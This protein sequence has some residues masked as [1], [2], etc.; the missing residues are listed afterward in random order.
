M[1]A[2][3]TVSVTTFSFWCFHNVKKC[4]SQNLFHHTLTFLNL[5]SKLSSFVVISIFCFI[6]KKLM[7]IVF[8][9]IISSFNHQS[10]SSFTLH[11]S[12]CLVVMSLLFWR[13]CK[14]NCTC[15]I[16]IMP[17]PYKC[18]NR[19]SSNIEKISYHHNLSCKIHFVNWN[20]AAWSIFLVHKLRI[21]WRDAMMV[22]CKESF[23]HVG[24]SH[25]L[26][27]IHGLLFLKYIYFLTE[28]EYLS[29]LYQKL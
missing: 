20:F 17:L 18:T 13:L 23:S 16:I 8:Y 26:C 29:S 4:Y 6:L 11:H 3:I 22:D 9:F 5:S 14:V 19:Q 28:Y 7:R 15:T 24:C 1:L 12:T 21:W 10:T 27:W 2:H 25:S